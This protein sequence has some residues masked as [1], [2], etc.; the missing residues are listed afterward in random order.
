M[1]IL[2]VGSVSKPTTVDSTGG[3][4][5]WTA[6]FL[7]ESIKYGHTYDVIGLDG[8]LTVPGKIE[9][10]HLFDKGIDELKKLDFFSQPQR[11]D[12]IGHL[13]ATYFAKI[14]LYLK[15]NEHKYDLILN[16]SGS[17]LIPVNWN[18]FKKPLVTPVHFP[19]TEPAISFFNFFPI[20]SNIY[21]VFPSYFEYKRSTIIP[22][23]QKFYVPHGINIDKFNFKANGGQNMLW[24]GRVDPGLPKGIE[25]TI[26]TA[27]ITRKKVDMYA[28]IENRQYF[29]TTIRPL[30]SPYI[31]F[32]LNGDRNTYFNNAK[33]FMFPLQKGELFGLTMLEAMATGTPVIAF[34][35]N[36]SPYVVKDGET[37]LLVN[38]S[39]DENNGNWI[40]KKTGIEG[41]CEAVERIYAMPEDQYKQMRLN[42]RAHVEKNFTVRTMTN[43]Y[44]KILNSFIRQII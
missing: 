30:L 23:N 10:I 29:D 31:N 18:S 17:P 5:V 1:K 19:S 11:E 34:A 44:E 15:E 14:L 24:Y 7:I 39:D 3:V 36:A 4:E 13:F 32:F 21:Y 12:S 38:P 40:V 26:K 9:V 25:E 2:A 20:P 16:S 22:E 43:A 37:G 42:C 41:L 8:T 6:S 35:R 28:Y 33:L 27:N